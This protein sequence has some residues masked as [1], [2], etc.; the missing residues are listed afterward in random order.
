MSEGSL[1][2]IVLLVGWLALAVSG[3]R[4]W[5]LSRSKTLAMALAWL[6]IF[7][8]AALIFGAIA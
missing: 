8:I 4:S 3:Y 2:Q 1:L 5:R 6:V 7:G